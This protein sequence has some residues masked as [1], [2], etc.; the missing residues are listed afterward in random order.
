MIGSKYKRRS[1]HL[2]LI[3]GINQELL[4]NRNDPLIFVLH[5][6]ISH[7]EG[8]CRNLKRRQHPPG[9]PRRFKFSPHPAPIFINQ[10][11]KCNRWSPGRRIRRYLHASTMK[12]CIYLPRTEVSAGGE[13]VSVGSCSGVAMATRSRVGRSAPSVPLPGNGGLCRSQKEKR[14]RGILIGC[15]WRASCCLDFIKIAKNCTSWRTR[16]GFV[17]SVKFAFWKGRCPRAGLKKCLPFL[18]EGR[19]TNNQ[20]LTFGEVW[21]CVKLLIF[22]RLHQGALLLTEKN[23]RYNI[24]RNSC[25]LVL[26]NAVVP[27]LLK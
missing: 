16:G 17:L 7:S 5:L 9:S 10:F 23:A 14:S 26:S 20:N 8:L 18:C 4:P 19:C 13:I 27:K 24:F 22:T 3:S 2:E 15:L 11:R 21:K 25:F 1:T 6:P 12:E